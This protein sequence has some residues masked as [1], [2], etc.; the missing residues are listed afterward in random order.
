[1]RKSGFCRSPDNWSSE[2]PAQK[3][4]Q[5]H[6]QLKINKATFH[7]P[8]STAVEGSWF[9]PRDL[10]SSKSLSRPWPLLHA[11]VMWR[12][13][14]SHLC[15]RWSL[16]ETFSHSRTLMWSTAAPKWQEN[17]RC[18]NGPSP[19]SERLWCCAGTTCNKDSDIRLYPS[20]PC[21][22]FLKKDSSFKPALDLFFRP[23]SLFKQSV[24]SQKIRVWLWRRLRNEL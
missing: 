23:L 15:D 18:C 17:R 5:L 1:M 12:Q 24:I 11:K 2:K 3:S 20:S 4:L 13:M 22:L 6:L 16:L 7:A 19:G 14:W 8:P 10:D 21:L 9:V